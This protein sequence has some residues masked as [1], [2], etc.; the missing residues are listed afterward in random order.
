MLIVFKSEMNEVDEKADEKL[1]Q[2]YNEKVDFD[3]ILELVGGYGRFQ[4]RFNYIFNVLFLALVCMVI[5]NLFLAL[6]VPKHWCYVPGRE[7][8][9][10]TIEQ[11]KEI[12]IPRNQSGE[13]LK[14]DFASCKMYR[15]FSLDQ[16][17]IVDCQFGYD[18]DTTWYTETFAMKQKWV[19]GNEINVANAF[20]F[21]K[22]GDI[23]G[24]LIF[25]PIGDQYGR[26]LIFYLT[27][28]I[29]FV[30]RLAML[31]TS[32]STTLFMI[33]C[34]LSGSATFGVFQ[35][36]LVIALEICHRKVHAYM[37]MCQCVGWAIGFCIMPFIMWYLKEWK[38]F[39]LMTTIPSGIFFFSHRFMIE[40]PR[41]LFNKGKRKKCLMAMRKIGKINGVDVGDELES[42]VLI[43]NELK[44]EKVYG[45]M[46]IFSHWRFAK[47]SIILI[48]GWA[49][50]NV[51]Y[52][53]LT[54][55]IINL[56]G[57]PF[58]NFFWQGLAE[59]PGNVLGK[60]AADKIGRKWSAFIAYVGL[61]FGTLP[62]L[63]TV[64]DKNYEYITLIFG[65][66]LKFLLT[67][68]FYAINLQALETFPTAVRQSGTSVGGVTA[69][70]FGLL[71]PYIVY[72]GTT[73]NAS[74]PYL[75]SF[76]LAIAYAFSLLFL[77]ETLGEKLPDTLND[78]HV[79]GKDQPFFYFPKRMHS[80]VPN[81]ENT[82]KIS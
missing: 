1:N 49:I 2:K 55:N 25:G 19:C 22:L 60:I 59:I 9:N 12:T 20:F 68:A 63:F 44:P 79:F 47:N 82:Q 7:N 62:I 78:A 53:I 71:G 50:E 75:I 70:I 39:I 26:R 5:S 33:T 35:S 46:S 76:T 37:A 34:F 15:N 65:V 48:M 11:W 54:M 74:I 17:E 24:G 69:N 27:F 18:F 40:S 41:W 30:S 72:L 3:D 29:L 16:N 13:N 73:T 38:S 8:T 14:N 52:Y 36:S 80:M 58:M 51:V 66:C 67:F 81:K 77:P 21:Q 45:A 56:G 28:T 43:G 64:Y 4:R 10:F 31:L 61:A 57:N 6:S 42:M 23:F 32:S